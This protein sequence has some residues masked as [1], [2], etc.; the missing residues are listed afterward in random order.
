MSN[1]NMIVPTAAHRKLHA[2]EEIA[3][4]PVRP[5]LFLVNGA[6]IVP[7]GV[8][9]TIH[10]VGA[11]SCELCLLDVYKRQGWTGASRRGRTRGRSPWCRSR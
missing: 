7:G 3:G 5:G 4:F 8:S 6:T 1:P 9:F 2:T 10:S 11:T